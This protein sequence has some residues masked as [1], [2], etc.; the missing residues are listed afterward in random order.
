MAEE[1]LQ[2]IIASAG[3]AARR[4][5]EQLITE[6]RVRV[7]GEVVTQLGAKA[8]PE[9]DRIEVDER[10][11]EVPR[12]RTYVLLHKPNN[13]VTTA[14]DEHGRKTVLE[15]VREVPARLFPVGR[16]DYDAEG[17]LLLTDDGELAAA[18]THPAGE[19]PKTYRAKVRGHPTDA[20]L[21][22][23]EQGVALDDGP[24]RATAVGRVPSTTGQPAST[25]W[26]ELTV[27]EGR[28]RMVK[29]MFEA[30]GHP[31]VRLRRTAFAGLAADDLRPGQWRR[32]RAA[33]LRQLQTLA[34]AA[35]EK[36]A[37]PP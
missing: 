1:R 16:L 18:L 19:V 33:E 22:R 10:P 24:A 14:S 36:R 12:T 21:Q 32:L 3:I 13:V 7:N 35:R 6:G 8:D 4:K 2:K 29:R 11:I 17:V 25:E 15:L 28:N 27:T 31:V 34:R 37:P 23:L 5:A 26:I 30:V 9:R 20:T